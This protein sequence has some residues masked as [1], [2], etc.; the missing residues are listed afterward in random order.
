MGC[1]V[2][3]FDEQSKHIPKKVKVA[4]G[5]RMIPL[6]DWEENKV[7]LVDPWKAKWE[8]HSSKLLLTAGPDPEPIYK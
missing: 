8:T 2:S 1:S 5:I 7:C 3:N 4:G 6:E